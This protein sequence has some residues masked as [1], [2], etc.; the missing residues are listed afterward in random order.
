M[1]HVNINIS[2]ASS[3]LLGSE[4]EKIRLD[5]PVNHQLKHQK[6]RSMT[7]FL[8]KAMSSSRVGW[9]KMGGYAA[10]N[11]GTVP[12]S[13]KKIL[14]QEPAGESCVP[15]SN[16][17]DH[18]HEGVSDGSL[19]STATFG[20]SASIDSG[21]VNSPQH[22]GDKNSF[23]VGK[24][25]ETR[26]SGASNDKETV[27][28][29]EPVEECA[30]MEQQREDVQDQS[31]KKVKKFDAFMKEYELGEVLGHGGFGYVREAVRKTDNAQVAV[32]VLL[33]KNVQFWSED[34]SLGDIPTEVF[35]LKMLRSGREEISKYLDNRSKHKSSSSSS[36]RM[37]D[38][39]IKCHHCMS[40]RASRS[41]SDMAI[42]GEGTVNTTAADSGIGLDS[43]T[44]SLYSRDE[45]FS[46]KVVNS[47]HGS[48]PSI[49]LQQS[50]CT[51]D[52]YR[53][54]VGLSEAESDSAR[55]VNRDFAIRGIDKV[56]EFIDVFEYNNVFLLVMEKM[57]N[58]IDLFEY[59][60]RNPNMGEPKA[61][62]IFRQVAD[63]ICFCH[64]MGVYHRDIKDENV[65]M[66]E[67][68]CEAKLI[69]FGSASF[70]DPQFH[71]VFRGTKEY[72]A[73]EVLLGKRYLGEHSEVWSMGILLFTLVFGVNPFLDEK[74]TIMGNFDFPRE[75]SPELKHLI[76]SML[77]VCASKRPTMNDILNHPWVKI[78][79]TAYSMWKT[80]DSIIEEDI[81]SISDHNDDLGSSLPNSHQL[82]TSQQQ[83][84]MQARLAKPSQSLP[85]PSVD[86][87]ANHSASISS[88]SSSD[89]ST[90]QDCVEERTDSPFSAFQR[91]TRLGRYLNP[92]EMKRAV[93]ESGE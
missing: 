85:M 73:P 7:S 4:L 77:S 83:I 40:M 11:S 49:A 3:E 24:C 10:S 55:N 61:N 48:V 19:N 41:V 23:K 45:K 13:A 29:A 36:R 60:E 32:K 86:M 54:V 66:D 78:Q 70:L 43:S 16:E 8:E 31:T 58:T 30:E 37:K 18:C 82:A 67:E 84:L 22:Q 38:D 88:E 57:N 69:D 91:F 2:E 71:T 80:V 92:L 9:E 81:V 21:S 26:Y 72:A 53:N 56:I 76:S 34:V 15:A 12:S 33:S 87:R 50:F 46:S 89:W 79:D 75:C 5:D 35:V 14:T 52:L 64:S 59:I 90:E 74:E 51:C 62:F 28:I 93:R 6:A 39:G 63:G 42:P 20:S 47:R 25:T 17:D 27:D 1:A 65:L 68:T 44:G